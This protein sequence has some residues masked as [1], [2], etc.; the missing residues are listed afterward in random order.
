MIYTR[1]V[2]EWARAKGRPAR[3]I[4]APIKPKIGM[5]REEDP[6]SIWRHNPFVDS[7]TNADDL[8]PEGFERVDLE[9]RSLVQINHIIENICFAHGLRPRSLR[10]SLFL[11]YEE[12]KWGLEAT[13]HM[14]RPLICLHPGG[15]TQSRP[16][17]PWHS[18]RWLELIDRMKTEAGFLQIGRTEFGDQDLGLKNPGRTLRQAMALIWAA[19]A[20]VG[21]DSSPMT[22]ATAF[23]KPVVALFDMT[24]KYEAENNYGL[25]QV[26]SVMLRWAYP[27][28]RNIALMDNDGG[29]TSL[30][31]VMDALRSSLSQLTYRI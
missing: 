8:D 3:I 18:S 6:F 15:N 1:L 12:M 25:T 26:P 24:R 14:Q 21:F 11:S 4:T 29:E 19:D 20:F 13:K 30:A 16:G 5:V 17:E 2:E 10:A 28:N 22:M 27:Q 7:I 31:C 9:R 23:E